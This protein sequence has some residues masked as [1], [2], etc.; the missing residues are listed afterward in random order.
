MAEPLFYVEG[1]TPRRPDTRLRVLQKILG[2]I[3]DNGSGSGSGGA[4]EVYDV[5]EAAPT[6]TNKPALRYPSTGGIGGTLEQ[7][8]TDSQTWV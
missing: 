8:Q 4:Q 5:A 7:W 1:N 6:P 3:R 2:A